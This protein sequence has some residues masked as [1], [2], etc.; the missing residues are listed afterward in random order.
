MLVVD[1]DEFFFMPHDLRPRFL[2]RFLTAVETREVAWGTFEPNAI[3]CV[4]E[5]GGG[6]EL[7]GRAEV[8]LFS[9]PHTIVTMTS[10]P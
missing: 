3:A 1:V 2:P 9:A 5:D 4:S 7:G 10:S 8:A 6:G